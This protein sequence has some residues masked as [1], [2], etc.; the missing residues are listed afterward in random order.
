MKTEVLPFSKESAKKAAEILARGGIVGIPTETVYGLAADA[1]NE[2][3]VSSIFEAKGRPQDNP[4]IVHISDISQ[5]PPLVREIPPLA[6][7]IAERFWAGALTM[8]FPKS[9]MIPQTTSGGLDTIAVRMPSSPAARAIIDACGFPLAA[10]SANLS[11]SPSPTTAQ[12][13]LNDMDGRI[14]LIID[15]GEC[16]CGVESTVLCFTGAD[17]VRILRPGGVTAEMLSELCSVEIDP[18]VTA[19]PEKGAKVLSPGMKYKHYSPKAEVLIVDAHGEKFRRWCEAHSGVGVI[20][21]SQDSSESGIFR[22]FG[23]N[24]QEQA[25]RLFS[26]L[27]EADEEGAIRVYVEMPSKEGIGLAVYNRLLR[28][29]AFRIVSVDDE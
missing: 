6:L 4:L 10:P 17:R 22:S 25:H 27:R 9:D 1:R 11:G 20:A 28:A 16:S 18:A 5:L 2:A 13:V 21:L 23:G 19:E 29:A 15:G 12:H 14:P 26:L 7:K 3:A 8:I 24:P